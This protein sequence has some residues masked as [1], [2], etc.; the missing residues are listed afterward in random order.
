MIGLWQFLIKSDLRQALDN[1]TAGERLNKAFIVKIPILQI[2]GNN[3]ETLSYSKPLPKQRHL[4]KF[5]QSY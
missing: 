1:L 5:E 2:N 3:T 4:G